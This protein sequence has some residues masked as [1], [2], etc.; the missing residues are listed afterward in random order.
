MMNQ[1]GG[2]MNDGTGDAGWIGI[3]ISVLVVIMLAVV[4]T[5]QFST[6]A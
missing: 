6:K 5:R 2:W 3:A 4:I 1:I